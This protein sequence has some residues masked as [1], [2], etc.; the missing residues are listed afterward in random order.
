[1]ALYGKD[2]LKYQEVF[3]NDFLYIMMG[4]EMEDTGRD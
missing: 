1:V 4:D 3:L 2:E